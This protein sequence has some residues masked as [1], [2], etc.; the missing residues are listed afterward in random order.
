MNGGGRLPH[1]TGFMHCSDGSKP[2]MEGQ[3]MPSADLVAVHCDVPVWVTSLGASQDAE[4]KP[5]A[6]LQSDAHEGRVNAMKRMGRDG[7]QE[8]PSKRR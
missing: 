1:G 5:Q 6:A 4:R 3:A 2:C 8:S 7:V